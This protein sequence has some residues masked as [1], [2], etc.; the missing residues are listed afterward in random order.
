MFQQCHTHTVQLER[1]KTCR[2]TGERKHS[3][4]CCGQFPPVQ[5]LQEMQCVSQEHIPDNS[6]QNKPQTSIKQTKLLKDSFIAGCLPVFTFRSTS[7]TL[8]CLLAGSLNHHRT[9]ES[10]RSPNSTESESTQ[11]LATGPSMSTPRQ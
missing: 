2:I 8:K 7:E 11:H 4:W 10:F 3:S 5:I 1:L 9:N 6:K